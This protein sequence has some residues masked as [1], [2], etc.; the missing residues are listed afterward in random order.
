MQWNSDGTPRWAHHLKSDDIV[1]LYDSTQDP[2]GNTYVIG[3]TH[4]ESEP[5]IWVAGFDSSGE[6]IYSGALDTLNDEYIN[7]SIAAIDPNEIYITG[8]QRKPSTHGFTPILLGNKKPVSLGYNQDQRF[9]ARIG[10]M[11]LT[12]VDQPKDTEVEDTDH[13][14]FRVLAAGSEEIQ[15]QWRKDGNPLVES[16][17][18]EGVNK[19]ELRI[20]ALRG[21]DGGQYD[22]V[23]STPSVSLISEPAVLSFQ[24]EPP[25]FV[26]ADEQTIEL[27]YNQT[28]GSFE[29]IVD[30][31]V[32]DPDGDTLF[33]WELLKF[34]TLS[35][36]EVFLG[37]ATSADNQL[38]VR[39]I[40]AQETTTKARGTIR[41]TDQD[42][43]YVDVRL[44][45]TF[46]VHF[47]TGLWDPTLSTGGRFTSAEISASFDINEDE[48][49]PPQTIRTR[50]Q[51]IEPEI[52]NPEV[53]AWRIADQ[54]TK[55]TVQVS[56]EG[57]SNI[58][59]DYTPDP[60][61]TG[62]DH[63][64]IEITGNTESRWARSRI[65]IDIKPFNDQPQLERLPLILA[66]PVQ[67]GQVISGTVG[68]W[69]DLESDIRNLKF[70]YQ[71]LINSQP[72]SEGAVELAETNKGVLF[73]TQDLI[74]QFL[75]LRV[76]AT[77]LLE[78]GNLGEVQSCPFYEYQ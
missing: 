59:Y 9:L 47:Y 35:G 51:N 13:A 4:Y 3:D 26:S 53:L 72:Q 10:T 70:T 60:N 71:W 8:S 37:N 23:I 66:Q 69:T 6:I 29:D 62:S 50:D 28:L 21:E 42:G 5:P 2:Q 54:P 76:T 40:E 19:R 73:V 20:R 15:Y 65:N 56:T 67:S 12:I 48:S 61:A 45:I 58:V 18:I 78:E 34:D 75:G 17:Q 57:P 7:A 74:G 31:Q 39:F 64:T 25:V 77:D 43:S 63:F 11:P 52:R 41:V 49:L 22:V 24:N 16:N 38:T 1:R 14:Y 36:T 33:Q 44:S 27:V 32:T 30:L 55:G 68:Q 46:L